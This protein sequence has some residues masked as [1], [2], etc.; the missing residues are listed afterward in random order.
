MNG[1]PL[2]EMFWAVVAKPSLNNVTTMYSCRF[3]YEGRTNRLIRGVC[4]T[5]LKDK[6]NPKKSIL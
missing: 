2:H 6:K 4:G 5:G 1:L 3:I